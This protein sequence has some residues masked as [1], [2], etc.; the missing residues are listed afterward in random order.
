MSGRA[1]VTYDEAEIEQAAVAAKAGDREARNLLFMENYGLILRSGRSA[2][3]ILAAS[4][5][6]RAL[7]PDDIDQQAFLEF[8]ALLDEW[9]PGNVPFLAYLAKLLPWRL[10]HYMRRTMHYRSR[11]RMVPLIIEQAGHDE[12]DSEV[13]IEDEAA[14]RNISHIESSDTWKYHTDP[15]ED[16]LREAV[17]LRYELGLSSREIA[18]MQGRSRRTIDRELRAAI[19]SIKRSIA[20]K[21]EDCS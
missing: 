6:D 18:S 21:W 3:R 2:R 9:Q 7:Q 1:E 20:D 15:L 4:R 13:D 12:G 8:C 11:V 10:L 5:T 19:S 14:Q 16:G 17:R